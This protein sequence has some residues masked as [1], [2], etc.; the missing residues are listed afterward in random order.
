MTQSKTRFRTLE[1]YAAL[2]PGDL[3]ECHFELVDGEIVK[4]P[5]ESDLNLMIAGYL[6]VTLAQFTPHYLI[7]RGTEVFVTSRFVTSRIP[8]LVVLSE[9][10][11][12]QIEGSS[13][14]A[15]KPEMPAPRLVVE[16]VSPGE[17]GRE[18]HDRDYVEK[19]REYAARGIPEYW[20]VDPDRAVVRVLRLASSGYSVKEFREG[21]RVLS[22]EFPELQLTAEMVLKGGR[23]DTSK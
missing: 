2:D 5:T 19:P 10:G 15:V 21:D 8:D 7:R 1:E 23:C 16:V 20:Q 4:L 14:S 6:F 18:N 13:R 11:F 22:I 9:E 17:P 3:P 12:S